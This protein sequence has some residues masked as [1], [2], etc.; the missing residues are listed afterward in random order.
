MKVGDKVTSKSGASYELL[1]SLAYRG[2]KGCRNPMCT[3][4]GDPDE[5]YGWHCPRCHAPCS[6]VGH[7]CPEEVA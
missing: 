2:R 7:K 4:K 5:C 3:T 6:M 1:E